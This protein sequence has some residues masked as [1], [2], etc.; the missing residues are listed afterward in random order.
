MI[1]VDPL[2]ATIGFLAWLAFRKQS[3]TQFGQMTPE[4]DEVFQNAMEF[5]K[6]PA[7][8]HE[9]A[10]EFQKEGLKFQAVLLRKRADW[11]AR[12]ADVRLAHEEIF[13]RA[14]ASE[15]VKGILDVARAFEEMTATV[16]AKQLRDHAHAVHVAALKKADEA[17]A[18][19]L[20]KTHDEDEA[21]RAAVR[22]KAAPSAKANGKTNGKSETIVPDESEGGRAQPDTL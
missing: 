15:N 19:K 9:L 6:D 16:K 22:V 8:M 17:L 3:K 2:T 5:L 4:R 18:A 11:R 1:P 13:A 14:M 20:K 10:N 7:R 21:K 12:P